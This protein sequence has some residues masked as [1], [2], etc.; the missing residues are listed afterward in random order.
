MKLRAQ[1]KDFARKVAESQSKRIAFLLCHSAALRE[2]EFLRT[3]ESQSKRI[4]FLL[5]HSAALR[6]KEFLR[7]RH[8]RENHLATK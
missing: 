2:K 4:A 3:A 7:S 8:Y 1:K 5:R 6:E